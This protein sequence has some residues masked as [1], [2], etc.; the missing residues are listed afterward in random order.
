LKRPDELKELKLFFAPE[1]TND[2]D[3]S[4]AFEA[5]LASDPAYWASLEPDP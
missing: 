4:V 1:S 5:Y 3:F 2:E